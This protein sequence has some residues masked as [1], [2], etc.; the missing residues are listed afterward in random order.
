[1]WDLKPIK[2]KRGSP[3]SRKRKVE[4]FIA[5]C[6]AC[7]EA[8]EMVRRIACDSCDTTVLDMHQPDVAS[9]AS[10]LAITRV[11]AVVI[12]GVLAECC[13]AGPVNEQVLRAAGIGVPLP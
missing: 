7:D 12:D 13:A 10:Q 3:M 9:R 11:P 1:M 5:G 2:V 8:V 6:P 4:I